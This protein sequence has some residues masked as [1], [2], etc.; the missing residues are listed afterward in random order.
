MTE[1]V[2][3]AV[4]LLAGARTSPAGA[5]A[6]AQAS[7][8]VTWS[9]QWVELT[10]P[11][12]A[13]TG[14]QFSRTIRLDTASPHIAFRAS[15]KNV[16]GHVVEWSMQ[17][18]SQYDTGDVADPSRSNREV[19]G[20]TPANQSSGYLNRYHVRFGP[21]ENPA[22]TVRDDGMFSVHYA[23]LAAEF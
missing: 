21:A 15:M 10:G 19:W 2:L 7:S 18:V 12:D 4:V 1:A 9:V 13:R 14:I 11:L 3:T 17:S 23:H 6:A 22:A 16:S 5:Q 20:F 8:A